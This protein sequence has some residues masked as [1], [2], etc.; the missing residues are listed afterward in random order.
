MNF[1]QPNDTSLIICSTTRLAQSLHEVHGQEQ[2]AQAQNQWQP[3]QA[4]TLQQW[5]DDLV[6][7][8]SLTGQIPFAQTPRVVLDATQ[9]R[10]LWE[11]AIA[12]SLAQETMGALFDQ[13][14]MA[15]AAMEANHL[16]LGWN[17]ALGDAVQT[18]E[19]RQ[20]LR[21]REHFR[22]RCKQSGWL[23]SARYLDWQIAHL[24]AG[25]GMLP[26][27]IYLAGFDRISPQQQRLFAVLSARGVTLRTWHSSLPTA[28]AAEQVGYDDAEAECRAAA[29]WAKLK[30]NN[31]PHARLAIVV[32]QLAKLRA[33]LAAI[34]DDTLQP[35]TVHAELAETPR[36]YD[37]SLGVPLTDYALVSTALALLRLAVQRYRF[38]QH[39]VGW[40]LRNVYWSGSEADARAILEARMRRKLPA[41]LNLE[42]LL[43]LTHKAQLDGLPLNRLV[44]QL[45]A[46]QQQAQDWPR[47]QFAS[48]WA[49]CFAKLLEAS[50]WPG[51]RNLSSHEYQTKIRWRETL[52]DFSRLDDL[53]GNL[54]AIQ[55]LSRLLQICR[56]QIFQPKAET[57]PAILVNGML[58]AAAAPL[59]AVWIMG[60]NDNLWPPP[61]SPNALLP[62]ALQRAVGA[63]NADNKV[64]AEF[65]A[66]IHERLLHSAPELVLSWAHKDGERELRMSPLLDGLPQS[67]VLSGQAQT[68]AEQLAQPADM[69]RLADHQAPSVADGEEIRGGTGLLKAQALC[70]AWA[71]YQYRLGAHA[72]DE[73]LEGLDA[74]ARGS[75]LHAVLQCFWEGHDSAYLDA[76]NPSQLTAAIEQAVEDG[77]RLYSQKQEQALPANFMT[78]EKVRLKRL[79]SAW[80]LFEQERSSFNVKA[81]ELELSQELAGMQI[82][83]KLDRVDELPD[84]SLVVIDYKTGSQLDYKSWAED[85]IAEP[86]L[87][88]YAALA[89]DG[90]QV[91]A[92]CFAKVRAHEQAFVGIASSGEVLPG[93]KD[94]GESRRVFSEDKFPDWAALIA[95]WQSSILSIAG[96]IKAGEAAVKYGNVA[97][98]AYCEVKPLLRLP[99]RALQL[100]QMGGSDE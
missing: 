37:F 11:Q 36:R 50:G 21:W 27:L 7:Q 43:R 18:E 30:L 99:E 66:T 17:I 34:L 77:V 74:M 54:D 45:T 72:L 81:C 46:M 22:K 90:E 63:P 91:A 42:Q 24:Q 78:L 60:M 56:E 67:G 25:V 85:R 47:K 98:L 92:V 70:P 52:A 57:A 64:Q 16:L 4:M 1:T 10:I 79:L 3:L 2:L 23:E 33:R 15:V 65:A 71:F 84:G 76:M 59:D 28:G 31:N 69:Q 58:E 82:T 51:E 48:A 83:L 9:E 97:D 26:P 5:L 94:L 29:A 80:L 88:V 96:E 68:L 87:P 86:Q 40:L 13:A 89:L 55:A 93:L 44:E 14:G 73:P 62:A 35:Q 8:A 19:T 100:Q 38:S 41:T 20:F 95:H 75:L 61:P 53:L 12:D 6:E 39:D 32:P 49:G